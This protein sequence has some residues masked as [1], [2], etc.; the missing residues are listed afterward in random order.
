MALTLLIGSAIG[1]SL[2]LLGAGGSVLAVPALVYLGGHAVADAIRASLLVVAASATAGAIPHLRA[3]GVPWRSALVFGFAGLGGAL[4][5]A[6]TTH[7]LTEETVL[8]SFAAV[9][10][11]AGLL[12]FRNA[13]HEDGAAVDNVSRDDIWRTRPLHVVALGLAAGFLSGFLG[14]G[15][16]FLIVPVWTVV[17]GYP[18]QAAV[19]AS[20]IVIAINAVA[21][22]GYHLQ[23]GDLDFTVA[24]GFV[25]FG[26]GGAVAGARLGERVRSAQLARWF[27]WLVIAVGLFVLAQVAMGESQ[28]S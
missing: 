11:V 5:G 12:M 9:M 14:V 26:V 13:K 1:M 16:G 21:G 2:G 22:F 28:F 7:Q 25:G 20:L 3:G 18:M 27:G 17:F 23:Y 19:G 4:V 24:A 8:G 15:G 6:Y 10:V